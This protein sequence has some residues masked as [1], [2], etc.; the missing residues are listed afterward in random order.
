MLQKSLL[1]FALLL[2]GYTRLWAQCDSTSESTFQLLLDPD[3]YWY[4]VSWQLTNPATG[5]VFGQGQCVNG[6][7][8]DVSYCVPNG[9]CVEF[10]VLDDYGDGIAPDGSYRCFLNGQ[11][12]FENPTGVYGYSE[13]FTF[14]CPPG[15]TCD[16]ALEIQEG[17]HFTNA[18]GSQTWYAFTPAQNGAYLLSTCFPENTC[19]T[20]IWVYGDE[21]QFLT[22]TNNVTGTLFFNQGG[23]PDSVMAQAELYLAGGLTYYIRLGYADTNCDTAAMKFS[24]SYVGAI[25]GCTDSSACNYNPLATVSGDCMYPGNPD[26]PNAPD[27]VVLQDVLDN[28]IKLGSIANGDACAVEEGCLRGFG[29]RTLIEFTTHIQ[30]IGEQDYYIGQTPASPSTPNDQFV[31]DPCHNHWHYRGYA[32]YVLFDESGNLVPVGAKNG[33]CVLDLE[34]DNGGDGKYT[35]QNMGISAQCGDIYDIGLPCQWIDITGLPAGNYTFVMRV[36]WDHTPDKLGRV[37]KTYDNNWAQSCF[38]LAYSSNGAPDVEF[39]NDC[40][41]YT[42]CL[43]VL[44]GTARND[45]EGVCNGSALHG[46]WNKNLSRETEDILA[47]LEQ[48]LTDTSSMTNCRDLYADGH[49]DVYDAALLQECMLHGADPQYWGTRFAC[50]FPTGTQAPSDVVYF[51]PGAVDTVAQTVDIRITN[52]FNKIM[53]FE[54]EVSGIVIDSI[55]NLM[56]NFEAVYL[57]TDQRIVGMTLTEMAIPKNFQPANV[58]RIHYS[59]ITGAQVCVDSVIAAVNDKYQRSNGQPSTVNCADLTVVGLSEAPN[60]AAFQ[61]TLIPNPATSDVSLFFANQEALSTTVQVTDMQGRVVARYE[62]IRGNE[63]VIPRQQLPGGV[64]TVMISNE[65]GFAASRLVWQ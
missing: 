34:C 2:T 46:D 7:N 59:A 13:A 36:N 65:K 20:K 1:I 35:C 4:E 8:V 27:L 29:Q 33:F 58:F 32:E 3:Q 21:C 63:V 18:N 49:L 60:E 10:K 43:G 39:I 62:G 61:M 38:T 14:N 47:Y 12:I 57:H 31:W 48:A 28:T 17:E 15:A 37:E 50:E 24:L 6:Q 25:V 5:E 53:G 45:C 26:C 42:D 51:R 41:P 22:L 52:P 55:E 44:H 54:L 64:Y 23:C 56:P 11:L 9:S 30:N 40:P 19:P 16:S